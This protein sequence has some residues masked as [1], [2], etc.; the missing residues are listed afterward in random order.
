M[1]CW[2]FCNAKRWLFEWSSWQLWASVGWKGRMNVKNLVTVVESPVKACGRS[3]SNYSEWSQTNSFESPYAVQMHCSFIYWK[4]DEPQ[5]QVMRF[6]N[7]TRLKA[8][9]AFLIHEWISR[10]W[11]T[12]LREL[13]CRVTIHFY[14]IKTPASKSQLAAF[15]VSFS[16]FVFLQGRLQVLSRRVTYGLKFFL[17]KDEEKLKKSQTF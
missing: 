14:G 12:D 6:S 2:K 8:F 5:M 3:I 9:C 4:T 16:T 1:T 13:L 7:Q 17:I 15:L 11:K 10:W